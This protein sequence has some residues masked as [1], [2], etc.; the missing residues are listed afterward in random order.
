MSEMAKTI[1][2]K[3]DIVRGLRELSVEPGDVALVHSSLKSF[4]YVDG[5]ADAVI[6]AL[7]D[8]VGPEGTVMVPTLTGSP[9]DSPRNP[10]V[11]DVENTPC[12]TG[13]I[14][15]VFR[16]RPEAVRSGHPTHSVAT[17][18]PLAG[19]L[20]AGHE[21]ST[22]PCG[23]E[24]PYGMLMRWGGKVV[25]LGVDLRCN[26]CFHGIEEEVGVPYVLQEK[27][28]K[29]RVIWPDG[30]TETVCL[31]IHKWGTPR[32]YPRAE[33]ILLK[34]KA[35]RIGRIG[36]A[37]VRVVDAKMMREIIKPLL[38]EDP[39]FLVKRGGYDIQ[40]KAHSSPGTQTGG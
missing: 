26:T 23:P 25:F 34:R 38:K 36:D 17:I 21:R 33:P 7:L 28:V 30:W 13:T 12:W 11:L 8:A 1:V 22:T 6:D 20:T 2:R 18:G 14:P 27:P 24:S 37:T 39:Y 3:G 4:G 40:G 19:R 5:G 16:R 29:A 15:E 10:P 35:M 9:Q 32:D 31:Y